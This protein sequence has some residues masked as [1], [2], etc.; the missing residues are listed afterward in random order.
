MKGELFR[1]W[2]PSKLTGLQVFNLVRYSTILLVAI[3]VSH[4]AGGILTINRY[5]TLM[6]ISGAFTFFLVSGINQAFYAGF[7]R[8]PAEA[9][10]TFTFSALIL[11]F[12][13]TALAVVGSFVYIWLKIPGGEQSVYYLFL[14]YIALNTPAFFTEYVLLTREKSSQLIRYGVITSAGFGLAVLIPLAVGASLKVVVISLIIVAFCKMVYLLTLVPLGQ[15]LEKN[16]FRSLLNQSSPIMVSLLVGGGYLYLS[17]FLAKEWFSEQQF[18]WYRYGAREFPLFLILINAIST[19]YSG[20]N[21]ASEID[22]P[23]LKRQVFRFTW[24]FGGLAIGLM[25][26]SPWL[27]EWIL[28]P[29]VVASYKVFNIFL[30]LLPVRLLM[31]QTVLLALGRTKYFMASSVFELLVGVS[32]A[33]LL[34]GTEGTIEWMAWTVVFSYMAEKLVLMVFLWMEGVSVKQYLPIGAWIILMLTMA[35]IYWILPL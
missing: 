3:G 32:A 7:H 18:T 13:S 5:E 30:F 12:S 10:D 9:K 22:L 8:Q 23:G 33:Y 1:K 15:Q 21:D 28:D 25:V 24:L 26:V 16:A 11:F 2:D 35:S 4:L 20:R 14:V 29:V 31:P 34:V 19:I 17:Q 27:F 6:M